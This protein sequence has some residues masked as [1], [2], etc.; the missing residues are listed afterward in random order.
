[1]RT[2]G[3]K[4]YCSVVSQAVP[5]RPSGKKT[6]AAWS[7]YIKVLIPSLTELNR[8]HY[9]DQSLMLFRETMVLYCENHTK[10]TYTVI[11]VEV[12]LIVSHAIQKVKNCSLPIQRS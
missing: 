5:A 9:N 7:Y 12:N 6:S 3:N 4:F 10:H 11:F 8:H 2:G 1:V